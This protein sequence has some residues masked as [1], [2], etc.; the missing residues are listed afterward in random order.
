MKNI[1]HFMKILYIYIYIYIY[2]YQYLL[3]KI[4]YLSG[5]LKKNS[6]SR[7]YHTNL[8]RYSYTQIP[9]HIIHI[10]EGLLRFFLKIKIVSYNKFG[11]FFYKNWFF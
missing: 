11:M 5:S 2:I 8:G 1:L 9:K 3:S 4:L 7:R 10:Q 6:N